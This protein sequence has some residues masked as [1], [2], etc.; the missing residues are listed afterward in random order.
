MNNESIILEKLNTLKDFKNEDSITPEPWMV[1][2]YNNLLIKI[3]TCIIMN[4]E[5]LVTDIMSCCRCI[6]KEIESNRYKL[7]NKYAVSIM[8]DVLNHMDADQKFIDV[9]KAIKSGLNLKKK[10]EE[11]AC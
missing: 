1:E 4:S 7:M 2:S 9:Q 11:I 3:S 8:I 5:N 6:F 10:L